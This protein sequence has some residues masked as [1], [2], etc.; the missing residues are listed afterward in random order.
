MSADVPE[1][2]THDADEVWAGSG[3]GPLPGDAAELDFDPGDP[4]GLAGTSTDNAVDTGLPVAQQ[5][6]G[7]GSVATG[8]TRSKLAGVAVAERHLI[9][10][11]IGD[12]SLIQ[13]RLADG[14]ELAEAL[15]PGDFTDRLNG[16][17]YQLVTD[18]IC[19]RREL[20]L[21]ALL[22]DATAH[23]PPEQAERLAGRLVRIDEEMSSYFRQEPTAQEKEARV[24][25]AAETILAHHAELD[26]QRE[27]SRL[28][29]A[30][31][32][33]QEPADLNDLF[34]AI[35]SRTSAIRIDRGG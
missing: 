26:W 29:D 10:A 30:G 28:S 9:A 17:A 13:C 16:M 25:S 34:A 11:F 27:R 19:D 22:A 8:P 2:P 24:R 4:H 3:A 1:D 35:R 20:S 14:S 31:Q 5:R 6:N 32:A 33:G 21:A 15:P 18:A 23:H 12:P 7:A